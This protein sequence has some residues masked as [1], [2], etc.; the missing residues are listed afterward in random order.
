MSD[1]WMN[2]RQSVGESPICSSPIPMYR[3]D[4]GLCSKHA[5]QFNGKNWLRKTKGLPERTA[6]EYIVAFQPKHSADP[7][8]V[9]EKAR[10]RSRA[11]YWNNPEQGKQIS[12]NY[13]DRNRERTREQSKAYYYAHPEWAKQWRV[14][15][16]INRG[17]GGY[18]TIEQWMSRVIYYG[19]LCA[20][21]RTSLTD[22]TLTVDHRI[23]IS[24]Q[25]QNWPSNLVPCCKSCNSKKRD[26]KWFR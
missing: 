20:Y 8:I 3:Q 10:L 22:D 1:P 5:R 21:C 26:N 24:K 6:S 4:L 2:K 19:W 9:K 25:G 17:H 11:R 12:Q 15:K 18:C 23:P 13:R 7:A 14:L 16:S